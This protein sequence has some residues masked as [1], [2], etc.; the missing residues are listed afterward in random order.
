MRTRES[1]TYVHGPVKGGV[2]GSQGVGVVGVGVSG[3]YGV[4]GVLTGGNGTSGVGVMLG[5]V[6]EGSLDGEGGP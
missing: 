2:L 4:G 6:G 1:T 5:V 3:E